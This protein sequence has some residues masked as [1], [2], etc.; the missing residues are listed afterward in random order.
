MTD[1]LIQPASMVNDKFESEDLER[2]TKIIN[3]NIRREPDNPEN[4]AE[5]AICH[6]GLGNYQASFDDADRA[7]K[8]GSS[9]FNIHYQRDLALIGL[10]GSK[11]RLEPN[12]YEPYFMRAICHCKLGN[13]QASLDDADQAI[14]LNSSDYNL[15]YL[16]GLAQIGL[17]LMTTPPN[18]VPKEAQDIITSFKKAIELRA[19]HP[20][21]KISDIFNLLRDAMNEFKVIR[22]RSGKSSDQK[23]S[24][25]ARKVDKTK[26]TRE[27]LYELASRYPYCSAN[28]Q[29]STMLNND[30]VDSTTDKLS[31][32]L[33]SLATTSH[34]S[35]AVLPTDVIVSNGNSNGSNLVASSN[36]NS[37]QNKQ[38]SSQLSN[39]STAKTNPV[40]ILNAVTSSAIQFNTSL[41]R[42]LDYNPSISNNQSPVIDNFKASDHH[43]LV[44][45]N[46]QHNQ[47]IDNSSRQQQQPPLAASPFEWNIRRSERIFLHNSSEPGTSGLH[48]DV[49]SNHRFKSGSNP[50]SVSSGKGQNKRLHEQSVE[51]KSY[52]NHSQDKNRPKPE[53][54]LFVEPEI[55]VDDSGNNLA[56]THQG[57]SD[58]NLN[59]KIVMVTPSSSMPATGQSSASTS[60]KEDSYSSKYKRLRRDRERA[61]RGTSK[62]CT[63][64]PADLDELHKLS[65]SSSEKRYMRVIAP[66]DGWLYSGQLSVDDNHHQGVD[67]GPHYVVKLDGDTSS[68]SYLFTQETVLNDVIKEVRVKSVSELRK[69]ARI[70][71]YWSR[72]YKCLST[73]VV[74]SRTFEET[75]SLVSVKYDNGDLSALP[76]EDLRL[77][78]PDYPKY[79]SNCDPLLLARNGDNMDPEIITNKPT[80]SSRIVVDCKSSNYNSGATY[81]RAIRSG[82]TVQDDEHL[83]SSKCQ[84]ETPSSVNNPTTSCAQSRLSSENHSRTVGGLRA[85]LEDDDTIPPTSETINFITSDQSNLDI[86]DDQTQEAN[87]DQPVAGVVNDS[88][89]LANGAQI[90]NSRSSSE[91]N[92]FGIEYR[93]WVFEGPPKRSKRNGRT[94]RD[95]YSAIRRGNE[96][97][98]VGDSAELMPRDESILPFIAKIDGLWAT[99][100]GEM[101]VRVRWY[102]RLV[103]TEGEHFDLKDGEN[104]LFETDHFDENDVQSIWRTAKILSWT[105]YCKDHVGHVNKPS[106]GPKIFY[107]AGYYDPVRRIKHLRSDVKGLR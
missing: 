18:E 86:Q 46:N 16:R 91:E 54:N 77:L 87:V 9:N 48:D 42:P 57:D 7:I 60:N 10:Y 43:N 24:D 32:R 40:T 14:K 97:L 35:N 81:S 65:K 56:N 69:G 3:A 23:V 34:P 15:H 17:A 79:M 61:R 64:K 89:I 72:Q 53:S 31:P 19:R 1:R 20:D 29:R 84:L 13:Y 75:K 104:A 55:D 107:L 22:E 99:S 45:T 25:P 102:Y 47:Q 26:T 85:A 44:I 51:T 82:P 58:A 98:S 50:S 96:V 62:L 49:V 95:T 2:A 6:Y 105:D 38:C 92:N 73:G 88:D 93:P 11:I 103:E 90:E 30:R 28:H 71:C 27:E 83:E 106:D 59:H 8:L 39:T 36:R 52:Y 33:P 41:Q 74:T 76:L 66:I 68:S 37:N 78:P 101:K 94:Y 70:C 63:I 80:S 67:N 21:S 5:R 4:Y 12:N 100:R